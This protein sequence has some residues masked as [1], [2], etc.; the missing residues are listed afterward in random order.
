[1]SLEIELI[2]VLLYV[3]LEHRAF[4]YN[5]A[6]KAFKLS[7]Q[8][9]NL[10]L[11]PVRPIFDLWFLSLF[12]LLL[13]RALFL[14]MFEIDKCMKRVAGQKTVAIGL[15]VFKSVT[16]LVGVFGASYG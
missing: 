1:M 15:I 6:L 12:L 13:F 4:R 7:E 14:N 2:D 8:I 9:I 10:N 11:K 3:L 16:L 5:P